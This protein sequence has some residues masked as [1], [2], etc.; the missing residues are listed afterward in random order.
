LTTPPDPRSAVAT[1][2]SPGLPGSGR[3]L[4][5]E[6]DSMVRDT[7]E[8]LITI[9]G[10]EVRT[11]ADAA[12][13]LEVLRTW[14][15]DLILLDLTLPGMSGQAFVQAYRTTPGPHAPIILMSGWDLGRAQITE[16]GAAGAILKPFNVTDL[17]DVM[18]SFVECVA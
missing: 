10:C 7:I 11:A 5:V 4:V 12:R 2:G 14:S 16:L 8:V 3:V 6:D 13:A 15:P 17:L 9:E 1:A 18:A